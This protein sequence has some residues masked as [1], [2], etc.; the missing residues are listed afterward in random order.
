M[1]RLLEDGALINR[2][3]FNNLGAEVF[4]RNFAKRRPS[5]VGVLGAN[6]GKNKVV[7]DPIADY[8]TGIGTF[9]GLADYLV[10]NISSPNTPGLRDLQGR[11]QLG[12]LLEA[13][14]NARKGEKPPLLL[15][16]APDLDDEGKKDIAELALQWGIDGIIATNTTIDRPD[17]LTGAAKGETGGLSGRPLLGKS[18]GILRDF[19]RLTGGKIPLIGVGGVASGRDAYEKIISGASLVQLYTGMIFGG[20]QLVQKIIIDLAD[21]L[22]AEGFSSL[23]DAIGAE[24][25]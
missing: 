16:I 4:H 8:V 21:I 10:I 23:S 6:V 17:G 9:Q 2:L 20:P 19:Y 14:V 22:R 15:K 18:T 1:F 24:N 3:G 11:Q 5:G 7:D 25:R 13:A 12:E